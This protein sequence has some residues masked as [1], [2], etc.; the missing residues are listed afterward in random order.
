[1]TNAAYM[2]FDQISENKSIPH[3]YLDQHLET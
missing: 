3:F 1:M 2:E